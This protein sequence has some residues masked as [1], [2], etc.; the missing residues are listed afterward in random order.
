MPIDKTGKFLDR[1]LVDQIRWPELEPDII[2]AI[3]TNESIVTFTKASHLNDIFGA[4]QCAGPVF[5]WTMAGQS[6]TNTKGVDLIN[7]N[8][9]LCLKH[10]DTPIPPP[11]IAPHITNEPWFVATALSDKPVIITTSYEMKVLPFP[12]QAI[13]FDGPQGRP[14]I[15]EITVKIMSWNLDG[16]FAPKI[17]FSWHSIAE[18][19]R[20]TFLPG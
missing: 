9:V 7:L 5:I 3:V 15:Y 2:R 6:S 1:A 20:L 10:D 19:V 17:D 4:T 12:Q 16:T 18:G 14:T 13:S 11:G 8:K